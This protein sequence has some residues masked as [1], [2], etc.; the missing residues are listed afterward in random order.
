MH[1]EFIYLAS[2]SPRRQELLRQ[3]G[4][5]FHLLPPDDP[6]AAEAL[7]QPLPGESPS[8]YVRRVV[9]AK[10]ESALA[11]LASSGLAGAPVLAADTTVAIGGTMLG[12]PADR[13]EAVQML[14]RL[15]GRTHRVLTAVALASASRRRICINVSRVCF[16]RLTPAEIAR[17]VASGEPF[18]KAGGYGIQGAA[19]AFVRRIEGSYSGIM[20]LP[21]YETTR[22]L[23]GILVRSG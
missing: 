4:V 16:S 1:A 20:G 22:L 8:V 11:R 9:I 2:K 23:R 14:R 13:D 3:I 19:G 12:K 21:L 5:P 17:Y 6:V 7:E 10:L 18:D 15:S